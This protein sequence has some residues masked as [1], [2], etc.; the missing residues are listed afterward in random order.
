MSMLSWKHKVLKEKLRR[1][2]SHLERLRPSENETK[3]TTTGDD[4][5]PEQASSMQRARA[6]A[7]P[8]DT[9]PEEASAKETGAERGWEVIADSQ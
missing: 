7:S 6:A 8:M 1:I 2:E 4:A 3:E 9:N 5:G